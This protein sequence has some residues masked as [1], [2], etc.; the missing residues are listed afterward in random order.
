MDGGQ[1]EG[2][3]EVENYPGSDG[4]SSK[5]EDTPDSQAKLKGVSG[6]AIVETFNAQAR[7][8][9]TRFGPPPPFAAPPPRRRSRRAVSVGRAGGA[10]EGWVESVSLPEPPFALKMSDGS[11]LRG[12]SLIVATGAS[13]KWLG[14]PSETK[15]RSSGV[16]SCATCDGA[17]PARGVAGGPRWGRA[18]G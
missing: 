10:V 18:R 5:C 11:T 14:L 7:A 9:G 6:E 3:S 16:S 12:N 1:L 17:P 2:T 13:T 8:F 4:G 15:Y